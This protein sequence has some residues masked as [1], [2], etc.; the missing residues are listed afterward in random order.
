MFS[1][2]SSGSRSNLEP[3]SKYPTVHEILHIKCPIIGLVRFQMNNMEHRLSDSVNMC[4][5][6]EYCLIFNFHRQNVTE[7]VL[8][9]SDVR[10]G[11]TDYGK[12]DGR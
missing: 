4:Q 7:M 12:I 11:P 3:Y 5:R 9:F 8:F 6:F 2:C 1:N 10:N